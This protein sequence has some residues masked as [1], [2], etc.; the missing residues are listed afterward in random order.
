MTPLALRLTTLAVLVTLGL[1]CTCSSV[2]TGDTCTNAGNSRGVFLRPG[3]S[4]ISKNGRV[5]LAMQTD[6]NLVIYCTHTF[7]WRS[8][9]HSGT[10][11]KHVVRGAAFQNDG[12]LVIYDYADKPVYSSG[13]NDKGGA[14]LVMQDDA[15][16]VIYTNYGKA[17]WD[18]GT[19][20]HCG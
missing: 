20:G 2:C 9:W 12:N 19:N 10:H 14:K 8:V 16:L 1:T 18:S 3:Q 15:N 11:N 17:V 13:S 5:R 6:G 7:P 4:L